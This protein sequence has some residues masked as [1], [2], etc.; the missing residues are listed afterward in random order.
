MRSQALPRLAYCLY[1]AAACLLLGGGRASAGCGDP[2]HA[3]TL[4]QITD[5]APD[6]PPPADSPCAHGRCDSSPVAPPTP[7]PAAP[8]GGDS[9][10][11]ALTSTDG[12]IAPTVSGFAAV[13]A[14][15][16]LHVPT[17]PFQPPRV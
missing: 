9:H 8:T 7:E 12:L 5:S 3:L 11:A 6:Q 4:D 2:V 16:P 14:G 10:D 17:I 13:P 15:E 1:A